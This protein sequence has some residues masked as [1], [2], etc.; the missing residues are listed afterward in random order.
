M[1]AR[2]AVSPVITVAPTASEKVWPSY[3]WNAG[4]VRYRSWTI[5]AS[6]STSSAK[7]TCCMGQPKQARNA[8]VRGGSVP[9]QQVSAR[10]VLGSL[11]D[12][13]PFHR[14]E[15]LTGCEPGQRLPMPIADIDVHQ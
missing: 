9:W 10:T 3:S 13:F 5:K 7:A 6:S 12:S 2:D 15:L 1:K 4:S 11:L 14:Q 8:S